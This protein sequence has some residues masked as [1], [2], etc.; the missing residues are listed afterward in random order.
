[1]RAKQASVASL[2]SM[3]RLGLC[4]G[5]VAFPHELCKTA[6]DI[7]ALT[8]RLPT[9]PLV[10]KAYLPRQGGARCCAAL[11]RFGSA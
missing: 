9:D 7:R 3:S 6:D 5:S 1:M 2:R 10:L 4:A 11:A 8:T